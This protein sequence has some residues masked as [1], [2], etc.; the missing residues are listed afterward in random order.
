MEAGGSQPVM[1]LLRLWDPEEKQKK[2]DSP[3][4]T[5]TWRIIPFSK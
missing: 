3:L 2:L 1:L 4:L 5:T